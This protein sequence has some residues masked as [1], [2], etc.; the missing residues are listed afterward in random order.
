MKRVL[1]E[2]TVLED[3][4]EISSRI[5]DN[6]SII[7]LTEMWDLM[8]RL[9][10]IFRNCYLR[11]LKS[12]IQKEIM[13]RF[14]SFRFYLS[15]E[16]SMTIVKLMSTR[17]TVTPMYSIDFI[18]LYIIQVSKLRLMFYFRVMSEL[19]LDPSTLFFFSFF[20]CLFHYSCCLTCAYI[21]T[22]IDAFMH[23]YI[24]YIRRMRSILNL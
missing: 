11:V 22:H 24:A 4:T 5:L 13:I 9:K 7:V 10:S 8:I 23:T 2:E 14:L 21:H 17:D 6:V 1:G 19:I 20:F 16:S 12:K 3:V 15:P 18:S